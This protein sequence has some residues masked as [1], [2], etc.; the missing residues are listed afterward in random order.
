MPRKK[1]RASENMS[2]VILYFQ[3]LCCSTHVCVAKVRFSV[4]SRVEM[5]V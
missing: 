5:Q 1:V 4:K 3:T 2:H